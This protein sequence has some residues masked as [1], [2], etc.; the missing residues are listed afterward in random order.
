MTIPL[1]KVASTILGL[2]YKEITPKLA[3]TPNVP[4]MGRYVT[5]ATNSTAG[6]KFW[7]KEQWQQLINWLVFEAGYEVYNVSLE[8][9][10]FENCIQITTPSLESK[11]DWIANSEFFI[12]L[13]SGL[14]WLAWALNKKVFMIANFSEEWA[15]FTTNCVHI[16][17]KSVCNGCWNNP[18]FKFKGEWDYCPIHLGSDRQWECQFSITSDMVIDKIKEAGF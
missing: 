2:D 15:E 1:Q 10:S 3:H 13:G 7:S 4:K 8:P 11:M 5:I 16:K 9:N 17:N 14:S 12:G 6:M 18:N